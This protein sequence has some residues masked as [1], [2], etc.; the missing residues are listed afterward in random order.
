MR[1]LL[2]PFT[3][4]TSNLVKSWMLTAD[5]WLL[6]S[7]CGLCTHSRAWGRYSARLSSCLALLL[8]LTGCETLLSPSSLLG[9]GEG[10]SVAMLEPG[11][12]ADAERESNNA[13]NVKPASF[14]ASDGGQGGGNSGGFFASLFKTG[15]QGDDAGND[16]AEQEA[17]KA[18]ACLRQAIECPLT[19]SNRDSDMRRL[20][21]CAERHYQKALVLSASEQGSNRRLALHGGLLLTLSERR[22]RLDDTVGQPRVGRENN[23]LL[24]AADAAR[25]EVPDNALGFLYG[26]SARLFRATLVAD[27]AQ[28]CID[29]REAAAMLEDSPAPPDALH[30]EQVRLRA[31]AVSE[32]ANCTTAMRIAARNSDPPSRTALGVTAK[33]N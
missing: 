18:D 6:K 15:C 9:Q 30:A 28:R 10:T 29:L 14:A 11:A 13:K 7:S 4:T 21:D 5:A 22:N 23:K 17:T 19:V 8:L 31:L 26:A 27:D 20:L 1:L 12:L 3:F 24:K 33:S 25:T 32:L 16:C 2:S